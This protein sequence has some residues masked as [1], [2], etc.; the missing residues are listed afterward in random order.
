MRNNMQNSL[1]LIYN[2]Q[3]HV[4]NLTT[5]TDFADNQIAIKKVCGKIGYIFMSCG[6]LA[7]KYMTLQTT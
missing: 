3:N 4:D 5:N 2:R 1:R 7:Y 6:G